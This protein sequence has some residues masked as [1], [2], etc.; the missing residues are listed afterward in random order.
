MTDIQTIE[1]IGPAYAEKLEKAGVK[2]CEKLLELGASKKGRDE[3]AAASDLSNT[4]ILKWVNAAD[5][6]RISGVG[7]EY[8]E[9]LEAAG[10]DTV[11][12]LA[13][14]NAANL[15]AKLAEVN[16]EKKLVRAVPSEAH[17]TKW[18]E[19]AKSLP[20]VVTH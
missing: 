16:E 20:K 10:V 15:A 13:Q 5:L 19:Q 17:T 18:I 9:L 11:P 4:L 8:A 7:G 3:I 1:G 6:C 2:T 12:E 14:R